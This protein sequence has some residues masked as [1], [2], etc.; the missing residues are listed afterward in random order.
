MTCFAWGLP[1]LFRGLGFV[2]GLRFVGHLSMILLLLAVTSCGGELQTAG[3]EGTGDTAISA[4]TVSGFG[5]IY[6]NGVRFD[7]SDA[8]VEINDNRFAG[9]GDIALGMV[10]RVEGRLSEATGVGVAEKVIY[11]RLLKG[12]ISVV[13]EVDA[14]TRSLTVLG[15]TVIVQSDI[16]FDGTGFADLASGVLVEVSG[17]PNTAGDIVAT[18]IK[19]ITAAQ[20]PAFDVEGRLGALNLN[21]QRFELEGLTVD[22]TSATFV[23]G[24][25][26][27]L[28]EEQ[29]VE[30]EGDQLSQGVL[31]ATSVRFK[32]ME[33]SV[34]P[35]TRVHLE[36]LIEEFESASAFR[37]KGLLVDAGVAHIEHGSSNQFQ[38]GVR[39][40]IEGTVL[41]GDQ[42]RADR[43]RLVLPSE[44]KVAGVIEALN[45]A[46]GEF[47]VVNTWFQSDGFTAVEDR[48]AVPDRFIKSRGLSVGDD[49]Q[50]F[51]RQVNGK[52]IATRIK[53]LDDQGDGI[54]LEGSVTAVAGEG[55]FTVLGIMVDAQG[56]EFAVVEPGDLVRVE[57][58]WSSTNSVTAT[59][60]EILF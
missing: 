12:S 48:R 60:V 31:T 32:D 22:Y 52:Y 23:G 25:A 34:S 10:V 44:V 42:L 26:G 47:R 21:E 57:G 46:A 20:G 39:V 59:S 15:Q 24:F 30:V 36:G 41:S 28:V 38:N 4:G 55:I 35:A 53:R 18:R 6:V 49:V 54:S 13:T 33:F 51:G 8:Q 16:A 5:S 9:E 11:D 45:P 56:G 3:I 14:N 58:T 40:A 19:H 43:I 50:V 29:R 2:R 7:T 1:H 17:F 37:V 27:D